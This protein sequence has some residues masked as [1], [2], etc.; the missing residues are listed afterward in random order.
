M[1]GRRRN[2]SKIYR[3]SIGDASAFHGNPSVWCSGE[4]K[5]MLMQ[6][7]IGLPPGFPGTWRG[8]AWGAHRDAR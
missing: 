8:G 7:N 6:I 2:R 1:N 4:P 3:K 5:S